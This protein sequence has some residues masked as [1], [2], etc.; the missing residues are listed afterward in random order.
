MPANSDSSEALALPDSSGLLADSVR[1][2]WLE[3]ARAAD[4]K[5]DPDLLSG[6]VVVQLPDSPA[7]RNAVAGLL[8]GRGQ[9]LPGSRRK[10][11]LEELA[12]VVSRHC[13]GMTPGAVATQVLGRPVAER[14]LAQRALEER[15]MALANG[16]AAHIHGSAGAHGMLGDPRHVWNRLRQSGQAAR[17][18]S[19]SEQFPG[20][21]DGLLGM[22]VHILVQLPIAGRASTGQPNDHILVPLN[23][24]LDRR[25]LAS[26]S[27]GDPH[28]LDEGTVLGGLVLSILTAAELVPAGV[29]ARAS[30]ARVGVS[31]DELVGGLMMLGIHPEGWIIPN[32][33]VVTVPPRYL[34]EARW[35]AAPT[36]GGW[37]FVTEN[38]SVIAAAA[39]IA[40]AGL[41]R[42]ICTNGTPSAIEVAA[43]AALE[44]EGWQVAVRADFDAAGIRHV[45][46]VLAAT[47]DARP[48]RMSDQD[49]LS[50]LNALGATRSEG[51]G[52]EM[53]DPSWDLGLGTAMRVKGTPVFEESLMPLLLQDL[54]HGRPPSER[55]PST[56]NASD[57]PPTN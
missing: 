43:V 21:V 42:L 56:A 33:A 44:T 10:V 3:L 27:T 53:P 5:G 50:A 51:M 26:T 2:F 31:C 38:P 13:P 20:G 28:A 24:T 57:T 12:A 55:I 11:R 8:Q 41:V 36:G 1:W 18:L 15:Q 52:Q 54:R 9:N 7:E 45:N 47:Q 40:S 29:R 6:T 4:R 23:R 35:P 48:W 46:S 14:K 34:V 22:L 19:A 30:W 17:M 37:V 49:Y 39:D 16:F 25:L 32:D